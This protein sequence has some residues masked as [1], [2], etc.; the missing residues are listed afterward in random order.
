MIINLK[1]IPLSELFDSYYYDDISSGILK[2]T[3]NAFLDE[4]KDYILI[5]ADRN[6]F[7]YINAATI[8]K[9]MIKKELSS[10]DV[11]ISKSTTKQIILKRFNIDSMEFVSKILI[12]KGRKP[13]LNT[14][15]FVEEKGKIKS[16]WFSQ[17]KNFEEY[18]RSSDDLKM[19]YFQTPPLDLK[20][21]TNKEII[22][23]EKIPILKRFKHLELD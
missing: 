13:V 21:N 9:T 19:R 8:K 15:I 3:L 23:K 18:L 20:E 6:F 12:T 11:Y 14:E 2:S 5:Y 1:Y 22:K 10:P 4:N 7:A 16:F 17:I